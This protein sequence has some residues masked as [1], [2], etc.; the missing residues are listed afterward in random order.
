MLRSLRVLPVW[1]CF[2]LYGGYGQYPLD[3]LSRDLTAFQ[4]ALGPMRLTT[5]PQ[6]GSNL[7]GA[8]QRAMNFIIADEY[9]D[10]A[11]AYIDDVGVKGPKTRYEDENGVP[12]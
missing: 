12:A 2:D 11:I 4:T 7:V 5:V 8:F 10:E 9:A 1:D 6:G 3:E